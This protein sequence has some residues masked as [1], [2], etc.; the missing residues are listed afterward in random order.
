MRLHRVE[1]R[2]KIAVL[3]RLNRQQRTP[4]IDYRPDILNR[5]PRFADRHVAELGKCLQQ[6]DTPSRLHAAYDEIART[7]R[8]DIRRRN[9]GVNEDVCIKG[10]HQ[11]SCISSRLNLRNRPQGRPFAITRSACAMAFWRS[12]VATA[13]R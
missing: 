7:V 10:D 8:L 5:N 11:R 1:R 12:G 13:G 4:G 2:R 3:G 9:R 6:Q